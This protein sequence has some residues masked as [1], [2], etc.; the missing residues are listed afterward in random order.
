[1]LIQAPYLLAEFGQLII[2]DTEDDLDYLTQLQ[3]L[4]VVWLKKKRLVVEAWVLEEAEPKDIAEAERLE[5]RL[6]LAGSL[7]QLDPGQTA[8]LEQEH[9]KRVIGTRWLNH[10]PGLRMRLVHLAER[11]VV[12]EGDVLL[13]ERRPLDDVDLTAELELDLGRAHLP[14]Y[15]LVL[16]VLAGAEP[17]GDE[18]EDARLA[19]RDLAGDHGKRPDAAGEGEVDFVVLLGADQAQPA[20]A[21]SHYDVIPPASSSMS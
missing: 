6:G 15:L 14:L 16:R 9:R 13:A 1:M 19:G 10:A 3:L 5:L 7:P 18:L 17:V 20:D 2:V 11:A 12:D 4:H 21:N 8:V